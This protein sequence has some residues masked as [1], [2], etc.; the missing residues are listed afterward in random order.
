MSSTR[1]LVGWSRLGLLFSLEYG[2]ANAKLLVIVVLLCSCCC[3]GS[4]SRPDNFFVLFVLEFQFMCS[5]FLDLLLSSPSL[6]PQVSGCCS[7]AFQFHLIRHSKLRQAEK[8]NEDRA[9]KAH[10]LSLCYGS[11][12]DEWQF[13]LHDEIIVCFSLR[14]ACSLFLVATVTYFQLIQL[15]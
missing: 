3:C 5:C 1:F 7:A 14:V 15:T 12:F 4:Q 11:A 2:E 9:E 10:T 13:D 6:P 8:S